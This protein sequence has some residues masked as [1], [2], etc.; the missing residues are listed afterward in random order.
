M[1]RAPRGWLYRGVSR[2]GGHLAKRVARVGATALCGGYVRT[3]GGYRMYVDLG[4][5]RGR[6]LAHNRGSIDLV[7]ASLWKRLATQ[8]RAQVFVDVGSNYGEI[9]FSMAYPPDGRVHL[10]ECNPYV[11]AHLRRSLAVNGG[12]F[13]LHAT[14]ASDTD[15]SLELAVARRDSGRSS[16]TSAAGA[17]GSV[18]MVRVPARTVDDLEIETAGRRMVF[19][20]DVEG[21]ELA[22]LDGMTSSLG[23]AADWAGICEVV[24]LPGEASQRLT[25]DFD[26]YA[27]QLHDMSL[28]LLNDGQLSR[29]IQSRRRDQRPKLAKDVVLRPV[30]QQL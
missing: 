7:A 25:R 20:I 21:H 27:V 6:H 9:A 5:R 19:K 13:T 22:V 23:A 14:A 10:V 16:V 24:H 30:G 11:L 15:D 3:A 26:V 17:T 12:P 4:D 28:E 18:E 8:L 1:Q 29:L 2:G